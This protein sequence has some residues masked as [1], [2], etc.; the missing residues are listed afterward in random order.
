MQTTPRLLTV[1]EFERLPDPR[2]GRYEL[3]H[4]QAVMQTYPVRQ[5]KDLQRLLRRLLEDMAREQGIA[6]TEFPYRPLP[7]HELWSA[8][9][10]YVSRRRYDSIQKWLEGSPGNT[11]A[12]LQ[13]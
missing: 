10:A 9:V 8:A 2:G 13:D 6:D 7:E 1:E 12:E 5:H 3:R 4:G 11:K